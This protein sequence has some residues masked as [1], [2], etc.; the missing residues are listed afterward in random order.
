MNYFIHKDGQQIGPFNEEA[1]RSML[2]DGR[3]ASTDLACREGDSNWSSLE[4][5]L[6]SDPAE[7]NVLDREFNLYDTYSDQ[8]S[9][10]LDQMAETEGRQLKELSRQLDQKLQIARNH[11]DA[12]RQQFPG[13]FEVKAMEAD[14][15]F[16]MARYKVSQQG[17]FHSASG[18]MLNRGKRKKS[19]TSLSVAAATRMVANQQ[20]KNRAMESIA[21]LDQ[22]IGTFDTAGARFAKA[23]ILKMMGQK[24]PALQELNYIIANFQSDDSYMQAR[25]LKDEIENPPKKGMCFVATAAFG[26]YSSPEVQF[27]SRFR[28]TVLA[29]SLSGRLFIRVY[30]SVGPCLAAI[31]SKSPML[32]ACTR[33]LFLRPMI[34]VLRS[35]FRRDL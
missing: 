2:F 22:S 9:S 34:F 35:L 15:L 19:L 7:V 30:Y 10:L 25:Q 32:L 23:T 33:Q 31:I 17:F 18:R 14:I 20:E 29:K 3:L 8:M 26:D 13:A 11:V 16:M 4:S 6:G 27:L 5:L 1:V 24:V 28:D 12:V 21:L